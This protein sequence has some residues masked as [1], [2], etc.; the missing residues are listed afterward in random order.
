MWWIKAAGAALTVGGGAFLGL[1]VAARWARRP[2][3]LAELRSALALLE[4]EMAVGRTPLPEAAAR[5]A[6][7]APGPEVAGFFCRLAADLQAGE[8][9]DGAWRRRAAEL[10]GMDRAVDLLA[11]RLRQEEA[12][13]LE[14]FAF[15][16]GVIGATGLDDQLKHL[17]LARERLAGRE[18]QADAEAARLVPLY[19]YAGVAAGLLVALLLA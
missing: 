13:D 1:E 14:P 7:L 2:H 4:T 3:R 5:V 18:R 16:G 6:A 11:R 8:P 19:R 12:A 15:L 10:T 17:Q 9:A